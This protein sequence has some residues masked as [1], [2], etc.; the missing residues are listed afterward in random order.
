MEIY[1]VELVSP[2]IEQPC[3]KKIPRK[4]SHLL[5][6]IQIV[7]NALVFDLLLQLRLQ[8]VSY[9]QIMLLTN[10]NRIR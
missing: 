8:I 9:Q 4:F 2:R 7:A 6:L 1:T 3:K 10:C 5:L